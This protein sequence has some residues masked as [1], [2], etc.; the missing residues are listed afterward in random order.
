[1]KHKGIN[2]ATTMIPAVVAESELD[3]DDY[4]KILIFIMKLV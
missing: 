2:I 4:R 3:E 1:M